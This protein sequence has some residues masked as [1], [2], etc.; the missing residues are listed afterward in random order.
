MI[1]VIFC[2]RTLEQMIFRID[3]EMVLINQKMSRYN[4]LEKLGEGGPVRRNQ[5]N[6]KGLSDGQ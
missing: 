4:I 3:N 1:V 6:K 5:I 2:I